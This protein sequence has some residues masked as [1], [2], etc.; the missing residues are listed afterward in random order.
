MNS[1]GQRSS[2]LG[3]ITWPGDCADPEAK[4]MPSVEKAPVDRMTAMDSSNGSAML[5]PKKASPATSGTSETVRPNSAPT[6]LFPTR[7]V[8]S[9][10]GAASSRS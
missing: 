8:T 7:M 5:M 6:R 3:I 2:V 1:R 4:R 10:S 9:D